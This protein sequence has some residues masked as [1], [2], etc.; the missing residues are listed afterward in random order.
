MFV[1]LQS[2]RTMLISLEQ[3]VREPTAKGLAA[4]VI[5]AIRAGEIASGDRLPPIRDVAR[6][7]CLS[8]T[9]VSAAWNLLKRSGMIRS[10][11]RRGTIVIAERQ[12]GSPR[13]RRALLPESDL[14]LEFD[15]AHGAPDPD[16]LPPL[17]S[18]LAGIDSA[19]APGGY[20]GS[21][22]I[23]DELVAGCA[24]SWPYEPQAWTAVDGVMDAVDLVSRIL[25]C[26][27]D[28]VVVECPTFPPLLDLLEALGAD[29]V[30]VDVDEEGLCAD[31]LAE[32][33]RRPVSLVVLQPRAQNPTGV[34]LTAERA[35]ALAG[36]VAEAGVPVLEDDAM[37]LI[38]S[39]PPMSLGRW[40]PDQVIHAR[41][42]SKSHGSELRLAVVS[43]TSAM[44]AEID[45]LR[46]FA[47][48]WTSR[49]LQRVLAHQ[50]GDVDAVETVEEARRTYAARR[51][52][53]V[54]ALRHR[55]LELEL[56][57]GDGLNLW[58]PV[59]DESAALMRLA[60][61][62]VIA[63]P[64]APFSGVRCEQQHIRVSVGV[65]REHDDELAELLVRA[66]A[67]PGWRAKRD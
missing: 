2:V 28:R 50:L 13:Y 8:P 67:A 47:Q 42:F 37:G 22:R 34:D 59:A 4:A 52:A 61:A 48:G 27:G 9:T 30:A 6:E 10:E 35:A 63:A 33:L 3:R 19:E 31:G 66:A 53:L 21:A 43:G 44:I 24:P 17:Q 16:L 36:I 51:A 5:A 23:I 56:G 11:G 64:G 58:L 60:A 32:A 39:A 40:V 12:P 26:P 41:G 38:A 45:G 15:L 29:V 57:D 1:T 55:G 54:D 65:L 20:L 25:V 18:A 46:Q 62:G 49:I 14:E 7:L